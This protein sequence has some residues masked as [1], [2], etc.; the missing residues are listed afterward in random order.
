MNKKFEIMWEGIRKKLG[1]KNKKTSPS[2]FLGSRRKG[3]FPK[4]KAHSSRGSQYFPRVSGFT[5]RE[6]APSPSD[7]FGS[8]G[9]NF[10]I[11]SPNSAVCLGRH[12]TLFFPESG[13]SP[14]VALGE[15]EFFWVLFVPECQVGY[16]SRGCLSS[17]AEPPKCLGPQTPIIVL[18]TS[19]GD[20]GD[21][22]TLE[23]RWV[24]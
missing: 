20:A 1:Q 19:D 14:S 15:G 22:P 6:R 8:R 5:T 13:S 2:A 7:F 18:R 9:T 4:C 21:P 17:V 23:V 24:S 3:L 11:L 16:G 12:G 10:L